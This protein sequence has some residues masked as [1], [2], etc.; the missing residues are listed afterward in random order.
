MM[1]YYLFVLTFAVQIIYAQQHFSWAVIGAGPAGITSIVLLLE[2]GVQAQDIVWIDPE[3]AVGRM[4]KYYGNVPS[5]QKAS[6]F[7][8]FLDTSPLLK[9]FDTP[10]VRTI[11]AHDPD[12]EHPLQLAVDVFHDV[13]R[14]LCTRVTCYRNELLSLQS[15]HDDWHLRLRDT[16]I[17][18]DKVILATGSHPKR[19]EYH[20]IEEIPLDTALNAEKL[21]HYVVPNDTVMVIGSA[22]SALLV[23]KYLYEMGVKRIINIYNRQ[24]I[25]GM[26]GGLEGITAWF[27]KYI[28]QEAKPAQIERILYD[29]YTLPYYRAACD[30]IIYAFGY[31]PNEILING[32]TDMHY[33]LKTGVIRKHLYGIGIAF[34]EIHYRENGTSVSL[35]GVNSFIGRL[36]KLMPM[37]LR[38][39]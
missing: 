14:Y 1:R 17:D 25:F 19:F 5:N 16:T 2:H 6:R 10:A 8:T 38:D 37:W 13:T 11:R 18:V 7:T 9:S 30:K 28:I 20:D 35:I 32:S 29:E 24:P 36:I 26:H 22:H 12:R 15:Q 27:A 39:E 21:K 31:D 4:G 23:V 34:P 3:F 33:D